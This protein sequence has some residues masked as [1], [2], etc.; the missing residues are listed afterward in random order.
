MGKS[1]VLLFRGRNQTLPPINLII[2]GLPVTEKDNAKYLGIMIDNKLTFSKH[3][4]HVKS[5]LLRGNAILS[6]TR[7]YLPKSILLNTYHAHIQ[8]HID[9]GINAWG[10]TYE[11][12]LTVLKR[13]QR[14]SI[15]L[16]NFKKKRDATAELFCNNK[17]LPFDQC[18]ALA[19]AKLLWK[20]SNGLLPSTL[21]TLFKTRTNKSFYLPLRRVE[22]TQNFST[23]SGVQTWNKL[24][25]NIRNSKTLGT[26]K[27]NCKKYLLSKIVE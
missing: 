3:I 11:S 4:E 20:C 5:K 23:S 26:F 16:I 18:L 13:C 24:P 21:S 12:H 25:L 22:M 1:N 27:T 10:H 15:R 6:I 19:S 2:N 8:P 9:Y 17:V 7:Q 14:K